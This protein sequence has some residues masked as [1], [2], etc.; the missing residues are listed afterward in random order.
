MI[1]GNDYINPCFNI[2]SSYF[3]DHSDGI[4]NESQATVLQVDSGTDNGTAISSSEMTSL[5]SPGSVNLLTP[6]S[7]RRHLLLLQ[8][9]QRSS[10]DT[11]NLDEEIIEQAAS[12]RGQTYIPELEKSYFTPHLENTPKII[13]NK[14]KIQHQTEQ[15]LKP[16]NIS[17][18]ASSSSLSWK[19]RSPESPSKSPQPAIVPD[20]LLARTDSCKTNTDVSESTTT[21]DYI[22][23]N[24]GTDSSRKSG[25]TSRV[26]FNF[27]YST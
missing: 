5:I 8:H 9:Q 14:P 12:T 4:W 26:S 22:T 1:L 3:R 13:I 6:S 25:S 21:D 20:L 27:A 19:K 11:E 2:Q 10:F 17:F 18:K 15:L 16:N 23:A 24:S 7:R